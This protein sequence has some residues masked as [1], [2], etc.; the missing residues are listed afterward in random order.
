M[1]E[2]LSLESPGVGPDTGQYFP[3]FIL[4]VQKSIHNQE[5][6]HQSRDQSRDQVLKKSWKANP[7]VIERFGIKI[8]CKIN[9]LLNFIPHHSTTNH[10]C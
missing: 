6:M 3:G 2:Q 4:A 5:F 7:G 1:L 8:L 10:K 9:H